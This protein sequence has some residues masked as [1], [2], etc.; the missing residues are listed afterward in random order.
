MLADFQQRFESLHLL[1]VH[2]INAMSCGAVT[3]VMLV[4]VCSKRKATRHGKHRNLAAKVAWRD[5]HGLI[6]ATPPKGDVWRRLNQ[7]ALPRVC[8]WHGL[9]IQGD[10]SYETPSR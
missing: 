7:G 5:M 6:P 3:K 2:A 10:E 4:T 1:R 8:M 9:R